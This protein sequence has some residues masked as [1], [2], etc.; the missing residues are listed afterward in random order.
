MSSRIGVTQK[1]TEYRKGSRRGGGIYGEYS[2]VCVV[3][4]CVCV[5]VY[6]CVCEWLCVCVRERVCVSVCMRARARASC[7]YGI[8]ACS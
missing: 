4:V 6:V 3:C 8:D 2:C 7:E 5:C 1:D